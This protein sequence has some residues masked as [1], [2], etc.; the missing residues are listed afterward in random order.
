MEDDSR[1]NSN[2][3]FEQV[4][5]P[6]IGSYLAPGAPIVFSAIGRQPVR[7]APVLGSDTSAVLTDCLAL[8]DAE[9]ARLRDE[10]VI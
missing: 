8:V 7:P 5:Q 3:M 6:G 4:D 1:I 9:V 2:P 10:G